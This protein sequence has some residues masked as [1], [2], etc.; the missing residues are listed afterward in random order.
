M[1]LHLDQVFLRGRVFRTY[2]LIR[3]ADEFDL[4]FRNRDLGGGALT[5]FGFLLF[6][7]GELCLIGLLVDLQLEPRNFLVDLQSFVAAGLVQR[8]LCLPELKLLLERELLKP[9]LRF[10]LLFVGELC[11]FQFEFVFFEDVLGRTL[12]CILSL[13]RRFDFRDRRFFAH[14]GEDRIVHI[15]RTLGGYVNEL[16]KVRFLIRLDA[17]V[18]GFPRGAHSCPIE[19]ERRF[20]DCGPRI[21][22]ILQ[23][24]EFIADECRGYLHAD[25]QGDECDLDYLERILEKLQKRE[26]L[27]AEHVI[28]RRAETAHGF[29]DELPERF[30]RLR[31]RIEHRTERIHRDSKHVDGRG[32]LL[33]QKLCEFRQARDDRIADDLE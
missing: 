6:E 13:F 10:R 8:E 5:C 9:A 4:F 15:L 26:R 22:Q 31:Y 19:M 18:A 25:A 28:D 24:F 14:L 29:G 16:L 27:R 30:D 21:D 33:S 3:P 1:L 7:S 12:L 17:I 2:V 32:S 23:V 20:D 11:E